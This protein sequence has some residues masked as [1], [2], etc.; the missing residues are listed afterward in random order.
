M[1]RKKAK[2]AKIDITKIPESDKAPLSTTFKQN[3]K[4]FALYSLKSRALPDVRDGLKPVQRRI[5]YDMGVSKNTSKNPYVKVARRTG[6]VMGLWHPHGDSSISEA[7]TNM[8]TTWKNT[9]PVIDIKGNNGSEFGDPPAA[10]RYIEGRL[11]PTGDEYVKLLRKGIVPFTSNYDDTEEEPTVLPAGLPYLLINGSEGV[12]VGYKISLPTHNPADVINTFIAYAKNPK[13]SHDALM[14]I[15]QGPDF[16]TGGEILNKSELSEIYKTGKGTVRIRGKVRY[17]K[18]NNELHIYEVPFSASG[19]IDK[20]IENITNATLETVKKVNGKDKKFP[21]KYPWA[22]DVENHSDINGIDIAI[23]LKRGVNPDLAIQDLYAKTPF[24]TTYQYQFNALNDQEMKLYSLKQYFKEYLEH[25]H[26]IVCNEFQLEKEKKERRMEIIKG[27][28]ILQQVIDEVV[29]SAKL[30][31]NKD[32]LLDVLQH[33]TIL[34]G[35]P[36][37]MHKTIKTFAFTELQ[38]EEI[39]K[40]PIYRINKMDYNALA[41]EGRKLQKELEY[42]DSIISSTLKRRNLIIKRHT[43]ALKALSEDQIKRK[44]DLLDVEPT[45]PVKIEVKEQ[46]LYV[47]MDK[48]TYIRIEEKAFENSLVTSNKRRLGVVDNT[49]MVYNIFLDSVKP[50][51]GNGTLANTFVDTQNSVVGITAN[52]DNPKAKY[53]LFIFENGNIRVSEMSALMT[54]SRSQ[55]VKKAVTPNELLKY[56]DIPEKAKSVVINNKTFK[57]SELSTGFG[58]GRNEFKG[59]LDTVSVTF[60]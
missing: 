56:V 23:T 2:K 4:D 50:T 26:E 33:G 20:L 53:G 52:I 58:R 16:P 13:I 39:A 6:N 38:A 11:T 59:G 40:L 28:L 45:K 18:K 54:K 30:S 3:Y 9:M 12:A 35:V 22:K 48:Y 44:T 7:L 17:D 46:P 57:I 27:L 49:G 55:K 37:K 10:A 1:A 42:A 47:S 41:V 60:K 15:L 14:D 24:E 19:S 31:S 32:E 51:T 43:E 21:P 5:I 29:M 8:S 25:E 34:E 36:K